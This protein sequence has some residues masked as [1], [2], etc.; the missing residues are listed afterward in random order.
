ME[1]MQSASFLFLVPL[2]TT[3]F[4]TT[5][6]L[7]TPARM[8]TSPHFHKSDE[9]DQ[10]NAVHTTLTLR[11]PSPP[12]PAS[13][14]LPP[15]PPQ[16]DDDINDNH[17][18]DHQQQPPMSP[19]PPPPQTAHQQQQPTPSPDSHYQ[20][21]PS[22]PWASHQGRPS[23]I[24]RVRRLHCLYLRQLQPRTPH[25]LPAPAPTRSVRF[26]CCR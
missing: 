17:P 24:G 26:R 2:L 22:A 13:W 25:R 5:V 21:D 11:S 15:L 8:A 23:T 6:C 16:Y 19:Q 20:H 12:L 7:A 14:Q 18:H 3:T 4:T 10:P 1:R 9:D